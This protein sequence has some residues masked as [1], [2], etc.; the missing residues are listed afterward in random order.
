MRLRWGRCGCLARTRI[1]LG[2][3]NY[4]AYRTSAARSVSDHAANAIISACVG[5]SLKVPG[6]GAMPVGL[7]GVVAMAAR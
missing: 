4:F 2:D 3:S 1:G 6:K 5:G 7:F